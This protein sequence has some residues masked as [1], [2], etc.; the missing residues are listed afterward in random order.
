MFC[1]WE[2]VGENVSLALPW[3]RLPGDG[4]GYWKRFL[5]LIVLK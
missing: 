5:G 2:R 3:L 1:G 4:D